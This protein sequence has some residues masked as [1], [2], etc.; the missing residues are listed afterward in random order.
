MLLSFQFLSSF[1]SSSSFYFVIRLF[2]IGLDM[3]HE[4]GTL[5]VDE[6]GNA[7]PTYS[8]KDIMTLARGWTGFNTQEARTNL[9]ASGSLRRQGQNNDID[10]MR[11]SSKEGRDAFPKLGLD[12]GNGEDRRYIGDDLPLCSSLPAKAFLA[13]GATYRFLGSSPNPTMSRPSVPFHSRHGK[14]PRLTLSPESSSLYKALCNAAD[15]SE[16]SKCRFQSIVVLE[17]NLECD[18][19][20]LPT[21]IGGDQETC[22]CSIDEPRVVRLDPSSATGSKLPIYYE[23]VRPPCATMAFESGEDSFSVVKEI[24]SF[25][26]A[27]CAPKDLPVAGTACCDDEGSIQAES[28]CVFL[29]ERVSF[30][31][32][33]DRCKAIGKSVCKWNTLPANARCGTKGGKWEG[34]QFQWT[35]SPCR[36]RAAVN[37]EGDV[38]VIHDVSSQNGPAMGRVSEAGATY[39]RVEWEGNGNYPLASRGCSPSCTVSGTNCLCDVEVN[40]KSVHIGD[41]KFSFRNPPMFG[42]NLI[43]PSQRDGLY[44]TD[45]ILKHLLHHPNVAPFIATRLIQ[46]LITSNPSPR[47]VQSVAHAFKTGRFSESHQSSN[48]FGS[49]RYGDMEAVVAA[50]FLDP[51]ARSTALAVDRTHGRAR[52]PLLKVMH[53]LR[54]MELGADEERQIHLPELRSKIGQEAHYSPSVFNFFIP[55]F[56]PIGPVL[57]SNLVSPESQLL[58]PPQ[59]LSFINGITSVTKYGLADCGY[60]FGSEN[61]RFKLK[62]RPYEEFFACGSMKQVPYQLYWKPSQ[63]GDAGKVVQELDIVLTGGRLSPTSRHVIERVY[64]DTLSSVGRIEAL[65]R[66]QAMVALSAEYHSTNAINDNINSA[67]T[68]SRD[69]ISGN[70]ASVAVARQQDEPQASDY[71]AVIYLFAAGGMDSHS[72]LVPLDGCMPTDLHHQYKKIRNNIALSRKDLL[73]IDVAPGAQP[74]TQFGIHSS[75]TTVKKLF[76]EGDATFIANV[77]NLITPLTKIE[78]DGNDSDKIPPSLFAHNTQQRATQTL[79]AQ[80]ARAHGVL[81]RL[82]DALNAQARED[83]NDVSEAFSAYSI[84]GSPKALEGAPGVSRVADVLSSKGITGLSI[85]SRKIES[86]IKAVHAPRSSSIYAETFSDR[87]TSSIARAKE[88]GAKLKRRGLVNGSWHLPADSP[89][90]CTSDICMQLQQVAQIIMNRDTLEAKRD[91][92]FVQQDGYDTHNNNLPRLQSLLDDLD[93]ALNCFAE[94]LKAQGVWDKT[95]IVL[96]S[97]FGRSLPSNGLGTDHGEFVLIYGILWCP[98]SHNWV[99][100]CCLI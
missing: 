80:N 5:V 43:D 61:E 99:V 29:S 60:G 75:L 4:N 52:E 66:A 57:A 78:Y 77:G 22:E 62:D 14:S 7:V 94:E 11:I 35:N 25:G 47:Y 91:A 67:P 72:I 97:D 18:G 39:F 20:C 68:K 32:A 100:V 87:V 50:I 21:P 98:S 40:N 41:G 59:V 36:V 53:F 51:E 84:S 85:V 15:S 65:G 55:S 33:S 46:L 89:S 58:D 81:G 6:N 95:A 82:G 76:E 96:A 3:L 27:M 9:E 24:G 26:S 48:K 45:A 12:Y 10:P 64:S 13:E 49:G 16:S 2:T 69:E 31:T 28:V 23:Y 90:C 79:Q 56:Q 44:E 42:T 30:Y 88:L 8:N 19:T 73:S 38:A 17:K 37:P 92:F 54:S 70:I 86:A 34:L 71:K 93:E 74:C 63:W 1:S 83:N